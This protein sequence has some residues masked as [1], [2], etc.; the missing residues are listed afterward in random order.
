MYEVGKGDI[1]HGWETL[2]R[3]LVWV[4]TTTDL[5]PFLPLVPARDFDSKQPHQPLHSSPPVFSLSSF[6]SQNA[7]YIASSVR[8]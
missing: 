2:S 6:S 1:N 3:L 5:I 7:T 8:S 4:I